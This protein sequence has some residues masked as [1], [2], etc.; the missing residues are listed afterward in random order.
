MSNLPAIPRTLAIVLLVLLALGWFLRPQPK[1]IEAGPFDPPTQVE[2]DEPIELAAPEDYRIT[3]LDEYSL[4]AMV[5]SRKRY[6]LDRQSKISPVDFLLGWGNVTLEPNL[7]GI[8]YSQDG[9]WGNARFRYDAINIKPR[10]ITLTT[11]N[12]HMIPE[13]GNREIKRRIMRARRGDVLSM[14]GYLVRVDSTDGWYWESSRT[15]RDWGNHACELFYV[16]EIN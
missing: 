14:K 15:R 9:R 7:S 6:R 4:T 13:F 12:T 5:M 2:I 8:E 16:T 1:P 3:A 11:A 10:E